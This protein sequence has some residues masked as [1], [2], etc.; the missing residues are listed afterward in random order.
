MKIFLKVIVLVSLLVL[1][2]MS[3]RICLNAQKVTMTSKGVAQCVYHDGIVHL[4]C[5]N[6]TNDDCSITM[7]IK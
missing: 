2:I 4:W 6:T 5:D 7:N 1:T 3:V